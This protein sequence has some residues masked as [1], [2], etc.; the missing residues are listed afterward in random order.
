MEKEIK[1]LIKESKASLV[2]VE[3]KIESLSHE[4]SDDVADFWGDLK[5]HFSKVNTK[6]KDAYQEFDS[7]ESKLQAHLSMMEARDKLEKIKKSAEDFTI[8]ASNKTKEE[9]SMA[10]LKAHLAKMEAEDKWEETKKDLSHTY[11]ESK[12]EVEKL[13]KKAGEE[14]HEIFNKISKLV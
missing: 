10:S 2:N 8:T 1:K 12:V 4:F 14:M 13:A 6:L 7:G 3:E 5:K 9:F 11:A